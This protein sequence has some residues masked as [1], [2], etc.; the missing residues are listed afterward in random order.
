M[1]SQLLNTVTQLV[2]GIGLFMVVL[3]LVLPVF[4]P[5]YGEYQ[6]R[7]LSYVLE[8]K[9]SKLS[10]QRMLMK[11]IRKLLGTNKGAVKL[12]VVATG[13]GVCLFENGSLHQSET[14]TLAEM[15]VKFTACRDSLHTLERAIGHTIQIMPGVELVADGRVYAEKLRDDGY[16]DETA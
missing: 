1:Q 11:R 3:L 12:E 8:V 16:I 7:Y 13:K 6:N 4:K 15:G 9:D 14:L 10:T 5:S 2:M